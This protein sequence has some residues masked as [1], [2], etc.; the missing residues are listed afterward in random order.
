MIDSVDSGSADHDQPTSASAIGE[1]S[2]EDQPDARRRADEDG[3]QADHPA[4]EAADV[5]EVGVLEE[6]GRCDE[7]VAGER[8]RRKQR[9]AS[10]IEPRCSA[11]PVRTLRLVDEASGLGQSARQVE[12]HD[13]PDDRHEIDVAPTARPDVGQPE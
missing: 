7:D 9:E 11:R 1:A 8:D 4:V 3:E 5:L 10:A 13:A 12:R 2:A 6:A